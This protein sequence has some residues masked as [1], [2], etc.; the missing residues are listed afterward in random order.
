[1]MKEHKS[2]ITQFPVRLRLD[3]RGLQVRAAFSVDGGVTWEPAGQ[4]EVPGLPKDALAGLA[5]LSH[6][7][8]FLAEAHFQQVDI[9][10]LED[11]D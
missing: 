5:V 2:R 8:R 9:Y 3:R 11:E 7:D 6:D 1:M 10:A 4:C